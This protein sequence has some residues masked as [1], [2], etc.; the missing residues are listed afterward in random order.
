MYNELKYKE[1]SPEK[2]IKKFKSVLGEYGI[3]LKEHWIDV[4]SIGT[5]S[6]RVTLDDTNVGTNGKGVTEELALASAY[7]EFFERWQ[8]KYLKLKYNPISSEF[9][10]FAD[11]K[12]VCANELVKQN[13]P[14]TRMIL[15]G[16]E[17]NNFEKKVE[18]LNKRMMAYQSDKGYLCVP[19][20]NL[21]DKVVQ[22]IPLPFCRNIYG[23]NGM[24]AGNSKYEALTQGISEIIE[25]NAILS[26]LNKEEFPIISE[27]VILED[28][29]LSEIYK[30]IDRNKLKVIFRNCTILDGCYVICGIFFDKLRGT[31]GV[32]FGAHP[33]YRI[34]ISRVLTEAT[35]GQDIYD[36]SQ[37]GVINFTNENVT[38]LFNIYNIHSV[39]RGE[40]PFE[41]ILNDSDHNDFIKELKLDYVG[42]N[43]EQFYKI[44]ESLKKL[45]LEVLVRDVNTVGVPAFHIIIP[46]FSELSR[47]GDEYQKIINTKIYVDNLLLETSKIDDEDVRYIEFIIG[48]FANYLSNRSMQSYHLRKDGFEYFLEKNGLCAIFVLAL[49]KIYLK[50]FKEA[51]DILKFIYKKIDD[52]DSEEK[53]I[54]RFLIGYSELRG[55][56]SAEKSRD[57]L[58]GVYNFIPEFLK[59]TNDDN[60]INYFIPDEENN[61][62]SCD[63]Y[64]LMGKIYNSNYIKTEL[65]IRRNLDEEFQL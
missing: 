9:D 15:S 18:I 3:T 54:I 29:H 35:Q 31:Y 2:S 27:S 34:A 12:R 21:N 38:Q 55:K 36:F 56:Y 25:R 19:Y 48:H 24:C 23:S 45:G 53:N 40:Y 30:K 1:S 33:D 43:R 37:N 10:F 42:S 6:V 14:I 64:D 5:Y 60:F 61:S 63:D 65:A 58:N 59:K 47:Y 13:D 44:V 20:F 26:A 62:K 17:E 52:R 16:Y 11:E 41:Y 28:E 49:C 57:I 4:S 46:N 50:K 39:S 32:N 7:G 8:N 51:C 22:Y